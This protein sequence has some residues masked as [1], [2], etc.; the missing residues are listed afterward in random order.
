MEDIV[1]LNTSKAILFASQYRCR[2]EK[3]LREI[4][5]EER[6]IGP[7]DPYIKRAVESGDIDE[8]E[9]ESLIKIGKFCDSVLLSYDYCKPTSYDRMRSW[10]DK[11]AKIE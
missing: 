2:I 8:A 3:R 4:L 11:V 5:G 10:S 7:L 6:I 1:Y 9:G